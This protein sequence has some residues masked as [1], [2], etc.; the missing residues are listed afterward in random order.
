MTCDARFRT[1]PS[2]SSQKSCVKIWFGLVESF[3]SYHVHKHFSVRG[4]GGGEHINPLLGG[5]TFD[6]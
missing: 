3:K 5:V 2:Y 4:G 6:L 1:W